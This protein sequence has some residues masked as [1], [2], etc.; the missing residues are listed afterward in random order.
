MDNDK[1]WIT[2]QSHRH[3]TPFPSPDFAASESAWLG[4]QRLG[5]R[6]LAG[7]ATR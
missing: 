2:V 5:A 1:H 3:E 4:W 7:A 6:L